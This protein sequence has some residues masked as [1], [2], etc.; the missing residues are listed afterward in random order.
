MV[1]LFLLP[2][3]LFLLEVDSGLI[4]G[5][6]YKTDKTTGGWQETHH[7]ESPLKET[8]EY[9]VLCTGKLNTGRGR[10]GLCHRRA[11]NTRGDKKPKEVAHTQEKGAAKR[12]KR[13]PSP[14]I[15]R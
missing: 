9:V 3:I 7:T 10:C 15:W 6:K 12:D 1:G 2:Q 14:H 11:D 4:P 13:G 5:S 8:K